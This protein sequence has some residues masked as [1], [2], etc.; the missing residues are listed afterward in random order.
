VGVDVV[1]CFALIVQNVGRKDVIV[2]MSKSAHEGVSE[3][4]VGKCVGACG[5]QNVES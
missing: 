4:K 5:V 2:F 1:H 3:G